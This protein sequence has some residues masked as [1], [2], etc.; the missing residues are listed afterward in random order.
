VLRRRHEPGSGPERPIYLDNHATTP[1]D[2]RVA[3]VIVYAMTTAFG[4]A[5]S[6]EHCFGDEA[7]ELVEHA[8]DEVGLLVGAVPEAV[9]FTSGST[10][11]LSLAL[12]HARANCGDT[13]LR[14]AVS[15]VE[16]RALLDAVTSAER[17]GMVRI[18][19]LPVDRAA[20]L[21]WTAFADACAT[22]VD[23][24]CVMAANNEVGTIYPTREIARFAAA[25]GALTLVDATQAAG[26]VPINVREWEIAYLTLS[27]HKIY[28]PKGVGALVTRAPLLNPEPASH[29]GTPNVPGI[30]GL[31]EACRLRRIEMGE[32]ERRIAAQR[33][34]MEAALRAE[35]PE[36]LVNGDCENRLS[37]NLHISVPGVP[38]DAV[39]ARIRRRLAISTG[40]A[41]SA[42]ADVPSHVLRA[43]RLPERVVEGALRIG[44]GKFTT[45]DEVARA[46]DLL[47]AAVSE[48]GSA[49]TRT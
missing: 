17:A 8:R 33:D 7:A 44:L 25:H 11:S 32:D 41:C 46:V 20:R 48:V 38:N 21:D 13:P 37:G 35:I 1:V 36:L 22:G 29:D 30:V 49:M 26:R 16:H 31:G 5:N 45:D 10:D 42:G 14:V 4:N 9:R 43:M 27:G 40:S 23:L 34:R 47:V 12:L 24:V 3:E 15:E 18:R 28:G 39:I 2:P 19:W 6:V